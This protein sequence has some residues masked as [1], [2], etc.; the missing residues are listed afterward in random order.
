MAA[1]SSSFAKRIPALAALLPAA[2]A[3]SLSAQAPSPESLI[4]AGHWRR[5]RAA[6]EALLRT[7]PNDPMAQFLTARCLDAAGDL[8]GALTLAEKASKRDPGNAGYHALLA[9]IHGRRAQGAGVLKQATLARRIRKEAQ[10]ALA[11]DPRSIEAHLILIEFYRQAP[12]IVGGDKE[13]SAKLVEALVA[14][15]PARGFIVKAGFLRREPG[16]AVKV[17]DL[18]KKAVAAEPGSYQA[19]TTLAGFYASGREKRYAEG[20]AL[21]RRAVDLAPDR[22]AAYG[23]LAQAFAAQAKYAELEAVLKEAETIVPDDLSPT[24]QAGRVLLQAGSVLPRA[25]AL[26][27][28]YLTREPE[29]GAPSHAQAWWRLGQ[30]LEKQGRKDEAEAATRKALA[31]DPR[32]ARAGRDIR[33]D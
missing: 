29:L 16:A 26:F 31:L 3:V 30:V 8:D 27:R 6:A 24:L 19:L 4:E 1:M 14:I 23:I 28:K 15:A 10:A 22:A 7:S 5:A 32:L 11:L 2:L 20:E 33:R 13:R 21:A 12:G 18:Y 25:E 9:Y 17:E